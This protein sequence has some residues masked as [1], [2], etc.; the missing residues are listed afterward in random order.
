MDWRNAESFKRTKESYMVALAKILAICPRVEA[1]NQYRV[2]F[3]TELSPSFGTP[4]RSLIP[5]A[6]EVYASHRSLFHD[7]RHPVMPNCSVYQ[8]GF[9][10]VTPK[11]VVPFTNWGWTAG[12]RGREEY[13]DEDGIVHPATED[14]PAEM[15][16][17]QCAIVLAQWGH[18]P[19][20]WG[21]EGYIKN[22]EEIGALC[23]EATQEIRDK[24]LAAVAEVDKEI[25]KWRAR[26]EEQATAASAALEQTAH[27]KAPA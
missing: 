6:T 12:I 1:P 9:F 4:A 2:P 27:E 21:V 18:P 25:A 24:Y 5:H 26:L 3:P 8:H 10:S 17:C 20:Q 22:R 13:E 11:I 15:K 14:K 7:F 19:I 16:P 23:D